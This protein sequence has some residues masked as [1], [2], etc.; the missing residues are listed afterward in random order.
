MQCQQCHK[1]ID[2]ARFKGLAFCPYC[3]AT[4]AK[5][6]KAPQLSFCPYCGK[7]LKEATPFCPQCGKQLPDDYSAEEGE[8]PEA[9][10][11][12]DILTE[13][14][15]FLGHTAEAIRRNIGKERKVRKLYEQWAEHSDLPEE[16]LAN[17][18][19]E[20]H[21][22]APK[23]RY[24]YE[25]EGNYETFSKRPQQMPILYIMLALAVL[26]IITGIILLVTNL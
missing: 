20:I 11:H 4:T 1:D 7:E 26:I 22:Q 19:T 9:H 6:Q 8:S 17:L 25:E 24:L 23:S 10:Q 12:H 5:K 21:H 14:K 15:E 2:E 16:E 3:G 18:E 13:S